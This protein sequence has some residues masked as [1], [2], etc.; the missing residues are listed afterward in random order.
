VV[1]VDEVAG[2]PVGRRAAACDTTRSGRQ[3]P[4]SLQRNTGA[5]TDAVPIRAIHDPTKRLGCLPKTSLGQLDKQQLRCY[6]GIRRWI[7]IVEKIADIAA[8][9]RLGCLAA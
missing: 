4:H 5:A 6:I 3:C 8:A 7:L 1:A 2:H 9:Q